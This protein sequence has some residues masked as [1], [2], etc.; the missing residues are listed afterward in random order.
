[1]RRS[2]RWKT[3]YYQQFASF[4]CS[5]LPVRIGLM[6][7]RKRILRPKSSLLQRTGSRV[8]W[9][10]YIAWWYWKS[11]TGDRWRLISWRNWFNDMI[12]TRQEPWR[13][14]NGLLSINMVK[15]QVLK[16]RLP[17]SGWSYITRS[18]I[19]IISCNTL[20]QTGMWS[21]RRGIVIW[22]RGRLLAYVR[23]IILICCVCGDR[24][25]PRI[26][27]KRVFLTGSNLIRKAHPWWQLT[28]WW[29]V[30]LPIWKLPRNCWRM[31]RWIMRMLQTS[32]SSVIASIVWTSMPLRLCWPAYICTWE[33]RRRQRTMPG[34]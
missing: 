24:F 18:Q 11:H 22:W 5:C 3:Y 29:N 28:R 30:L 1:M 6:W 19:S 7:I 34:R 8:R 33:I 4:R 17:R 14:R 15:R 13:M 10:G 32:L 16:M 25:I 2:T 9:P 23:F 31:I 12:I 26:R 21:W 20:R 27:Q